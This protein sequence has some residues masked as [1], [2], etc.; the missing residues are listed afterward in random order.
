MDEL[1]LANRFDRHR[2]QLRAVA[3]RILGS[4]SE[5]EDA[6]QETWLRLQQTDARQIDSLC[7]MTT[8]P[9]ALQL[10]GY[11]CA[12]AAS[13]SGNERSRRSRS[14]TR[15]AHARSN[16]DGDLAMLVAPP[17]GKRR[18]IP[19]LRHNTPRGHP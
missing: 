1:E 17:I 13:A 4:L 5:A 7:V 18:E 14:R 3:Y 11:S 10:S 12:A 19:I 2:A 6:V 16:P 15:Q 9:K 8:R